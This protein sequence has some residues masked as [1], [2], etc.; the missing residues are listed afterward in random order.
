MASKVTRG[1]KGQ[2][3]MRC[4]VRKPKNSKKKTMRK[5]ALKTCGKLD[6]ANPAPTYPQTGHHSRN[7]FDWVFPMGPLLCDIILREN[8]I[9]HLYKNL[10]NSIH[11]IFYFA[12][13][14]ISL[15]DRYESRNLAHKNIAQC[16]LYPQALCPQQSDRVGFSPTIEI[17]LTT[18]IF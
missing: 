1:V 7:M 6:W 12:S 4:Q 3:G 11:N 5:M 9:N 10:S 16:K 18:D 2:D 17:F 8:I 14:M 13:K 15:D